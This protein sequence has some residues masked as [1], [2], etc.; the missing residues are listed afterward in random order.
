[1]LARAVGVTR[2]ESPLRHAAFAVCAP[3]SLV[4]AST[5]ARHEPPPKSLHV[6][7]DRPP[8]WTITFFAIANRCSP[9][10]FTRAIGRNADTMSHAGGRDSLRHGPS[11]WYGSSDRTSRTRPRARPIRCTN[12]ARRPAADV[13]HTAPPKHHSRAPQHR[14]GIPPTTE[15]RRS[16]PTLRY[17]MTAQ[18][19]R[20]TT[21]PYHSPRTTTTPPRTAARPSPWGIASRHQ[22]GLTARPGFGCGRL[23]ARI[24]PALMAARWLRRRG[25]LR[26]AAA[27]RGARS[28]QGFALRAA[29]RPCRPLRSA[30]RWWPARPPRRLHQ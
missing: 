4:G 9:C 17:A 3:S 2:G 20:T 7:S 8:G 16:T 19:A 30:V 29:S 21:A 27:Y 28:R 5:R 15:N 1:M 24:A 13:R 14:H 11:V 26:R 6:Q 12:A 10:T 23:R 18:H 25:G 22:P